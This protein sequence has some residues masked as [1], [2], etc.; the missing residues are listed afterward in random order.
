MSNIFFGEVLTLKNMTQMGLA[1]SA[2]DFDT[3][4]I[5]IGMRFT[6]PEFPRQ[7][8]ANRNPNG[9]FSVER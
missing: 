9:N 7:N 5:G 6:A 4:T 2:G 1:V 8:S 3:P